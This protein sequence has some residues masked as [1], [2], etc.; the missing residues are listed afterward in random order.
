M[1]SDGRRIESSSGGLG[2][3]SLAKQMAE[4]AHLEVLSRLASMMWL[5]G[6]EELG[7]NLARASFERG[8]TL[9][10]VLN[11][12]VCHPRSL[13]VLGE[14]TDSRDDADPVRLLA[15]VVVGDREVFEF[16][17]ATEGNQPWQDGKED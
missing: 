11:T 14:E 17:T 9:Q 4:M 1:G 12:Q 16:A 10:F 15:D 2:Q 8:T 3:S 13:C 7:D 6:R 5:D